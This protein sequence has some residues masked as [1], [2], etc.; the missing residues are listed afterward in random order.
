[1]GAAGV[2]A[3]YQFTLDATSNLRQKD[4]CYSEALAGFAAG[5]SVGVASAYRL[6]FWGTCTDPSQ[7]EA[8]RSCSE[9]E[10]PFP[11]S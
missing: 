11:P 2:G 8:F 1:L 6:L 5:M 4:D 10:P 7:G 3:T 9:P